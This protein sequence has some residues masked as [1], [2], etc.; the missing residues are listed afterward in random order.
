MFS[1]QL[2]QLLEY[3]QWKSFLFPIEFYARLSKY[4]PFNL[5][6]M[7]RGFISFLFLKN[8]FVN[9]VELTSALSQ[10]K[11]WR[12]TEIYVQKI[13]TKTLHNHVSDLIVPD[14]FNTPDN[15]S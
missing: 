1:D 12:N 4:L 5:I 9:N 3:T 10:H 7:R 8:A 15:I 14:L 13:L 11:S 2:I 6:M